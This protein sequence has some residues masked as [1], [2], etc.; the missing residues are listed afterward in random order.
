M[1]YDQ[2]EDSGGRRKGFNNVHSTCLRFRLNSS[3][4]RKTAPVLMIFLEI[5]SFEKQRGDVSYF[6][7]RVGNMVTGL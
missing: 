7:V 5:M 1:A 4:F 3:L 2:R 6:P